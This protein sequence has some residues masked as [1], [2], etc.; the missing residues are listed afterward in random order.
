MKPSR[1]MMK[2]KSIF[3]WQPIGYPGSKSGIAM[4]STRVVLLEDVDIDVDVES[5]PLVDELLVDP[6][7]L[8]PVVSKGRLVGA[9]VPNPDASGSTRLQAHASISAGSRVQS[10]SLRVLLRCVIAG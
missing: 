10:G 8:S 1:E 2:R 3:P 4:S 5:A 7:E 6:V 9:G